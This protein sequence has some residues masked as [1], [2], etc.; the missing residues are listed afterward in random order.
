MGIYL[1]DIANGFSVKEKCQICKPYEAKDV[2]VHKKPCLL[3]WNLQ[4]IYCTRVKAEKPYFISVYATSI[5]LCVN[6][7]QCTLS[8]AVKSLMVSVMNE[9]YMFKKLGAEQ[10]CCLP[11]KCHDGVLF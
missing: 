9:P 6:T 10:V 1:T 2:T 11:Y 8:T 5:F 4:T 3:A 7:V